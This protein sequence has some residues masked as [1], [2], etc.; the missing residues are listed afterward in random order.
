[1]KVNFSR[2]LRQLKKKIL[3]FGERMEKFSFLENQI[4]HVFPP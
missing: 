3:L 2:K 4:K 1:M